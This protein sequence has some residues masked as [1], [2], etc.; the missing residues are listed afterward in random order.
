MVDG[1]FLFIHA[2]VRP[3]MLHARTVRPPHRKA[4]LVTIDTKVVERLQANGM[5]VIRDGSFVAVAGAEEFPVIRA[6]ER[7][8]LACTWDARGGLDETNVFELLTENPRTSLRVEDGAP[9]DAPLPETP[10]TPS[11]SARYQRP[12]QLHGSLAPSAA[13]T[14]FQDGKLLVLSHAQGI[15]PLRDSMAEALGMAVEDVE[16]THVPGS[17]CYGHNGADDA[18]FEAALIAR[19]IPARPILLKWTRRDEH[20]WEPVAPA[21]AVDVAANIEDGRITMWS[22]AAYSDTH[23]GRPRPGPDRAGP[24]RF[25]AGQLRASPETPYVASPNMG[26]HA[27]LHRNLDPV[28]DIA[29]K[30]L[31]KHLVQDLPLRTSAMRCL[32]GAA[33]T[34]AIESAMDELAREQGLNPLAFRKAHL[35]DPRAH[36]VLD[37]VADSAHWL[38]EKQ[39]GAGRGFA[40]AQYKNAMTR[41]AVLVDLEVR[42]TGEVRLSRALIVGDSGRIIDSNG[43]R[44]QLEGGFIQAASW[45]L[46]EEVTY[47]RGGVTSEDWEAY[48]VIRFDGIPRIETILL[49]YHEEKSLG[50]GEAS[51]GPTIAAIANAIHDAAGLRL[52]KLPFRSDRILEAALA[53]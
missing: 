5:T 45:S 7:L 35:S 20:R 12:Y 37:A 27:G 53:Q 51:C 2:T 11:F 43:L 26:R 21:M 50:A 49:P 4:R 47:D 15:Y 19:A 9:T 48:P 16:I 46:F 10:E 23:R 3:A 25:A 38:G 24:A 32:G 36:R 30:R 44:A 22:Q 28:Y 18:A 41:V 42:D 40:Y 6:A 52:R 1:S 17:G 31:T 29:D 13:L 8:A 34:F 33:N 14:E 39:E